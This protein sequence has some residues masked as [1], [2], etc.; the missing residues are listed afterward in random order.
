MPVDRIARWPAVAEASRP[1]QLALIL[2][3]VGG[4]VSLTPLADA[5][6]LHQTWIPGVFDEASPIDTPIAS[7]EIPALPCLSARFSSPVVFVIGSVPPGSE[8]GVSA[9]C[10]EASRT[11]APPLG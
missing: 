3:L 9:P 4:I 7:L 1:Y 2:L 10:P 11:R 6:P 8:A 5:G